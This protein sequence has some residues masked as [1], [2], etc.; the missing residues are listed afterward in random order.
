[1]MFDSAEAHNGG[2]RAVDRW[3]IAGCSLR[4]L[5]SSWQPDL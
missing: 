2:D 3:K 1:M 4:R 5:W